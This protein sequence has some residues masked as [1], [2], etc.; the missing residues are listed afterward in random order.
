MSGETQRTEKDFPC[1]LAGKKSERNCRKRF[2]L[3]IK[4]RDRE[5]RKRFSLESEQEKKRVSEMTEKEYPK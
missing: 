3:Q 4:Q 1:E 2:S 5:N